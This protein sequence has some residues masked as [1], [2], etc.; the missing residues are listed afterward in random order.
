MRPDTWCRISLKIS[1]W[2]IPA[3]QESRWRNQIFSPAWYDD[4]KISSLSTAI[5]TILR[6]WKRN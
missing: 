4:L 1:N 2:A 3:L 5:L 6:Q